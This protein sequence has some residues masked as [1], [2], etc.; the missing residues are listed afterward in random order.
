MSPQSAERPTLALVRL[1][2]DTR[3]QTGIVADRPSKLEFLG[4]E[5][6]RDVLIQLTG[7]GLGQ[8]LARQCFHHHELSPPI[9]TG[10]GEPVAWL[11][12]PV[13]FGPLSVDLDLPSSAGALR[14]R[15]CFE[16]AGDVQPDI[17]PESGLGGGV[18]HA[19]F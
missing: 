9:A 3:R 12:E 14:L 17:Q 16:E 15:A 10:N 2:G 7:V 6:G 1:T 8:V 13:R 5:P 18:C 4:S 11:G 19:A